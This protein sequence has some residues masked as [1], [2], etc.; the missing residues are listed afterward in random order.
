VTSGL[1]P[2]KI[3][4]AAEMYA[5]CVAG[6]LKK[7]DYLALIKN[8]GFENIRVVKE[9]PITVPDEILLQYLD[10]D[11]LDRYRASNNAILSITV[12]AEKQ[13]CSSPGCCR[14]TAS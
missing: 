5:G 4:G 7:S 9:K 13:A 3:L 14:T 8:A 6:A 11:E 1:L 12:Y 2:E 10:K